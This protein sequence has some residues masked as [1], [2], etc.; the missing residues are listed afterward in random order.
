[1]LKLRRAIL[2]LVGWL[3]SFSL[4]LNSNREVDDVQKHPHRHI[5]KQA[6]SAAWTLTQSS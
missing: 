2:P 3:V 5:K 6:L 1:M 4:P